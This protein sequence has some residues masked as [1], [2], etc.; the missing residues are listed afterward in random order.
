M[1]SPPVIQNSP[2][3]E[4]AD[5]FYKIR[6][7]GNLFHCCLHGNLSECEGAS[8]GDVVRSITNIGKDQLSVRKRNLEQ[9]ACGFPSPAADHTEGS[10][11]LVR[12]VVRRVDVGD[13]WGV[14]KKY[15]ERLAGFNIR[16]AHDLAEM[17][18]KWIRREFGVVLE[19]TAAELRGEVAHELETQPDDRKSCTCSRSF[20]M[21]A[22]TAQGAAQRAAETN[23]TV[24]T[25]IGPLIRSRA[26]SS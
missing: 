10:L 25:L 2:L 16:T 17:E 12:L 9:A 11:D 3:C 19:R 20:T 23:S 1:A 13:V 7:K 8:I 15:A 24:D 6:L 18:P 21:S 5:D 4:I 14:G 26:W 22:D